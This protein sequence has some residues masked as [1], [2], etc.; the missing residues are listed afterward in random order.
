[1]GQ[2]GWLIAVLLAGACAPRAPARTIRFESTVHSAR[3]PNGMRVL[4]L[5]DHDTNLVEVAIRLDVGS[6]DDPQGKGGLAHLVE[7]LMF[8]IESP[9]DR[10]PVRAHLSAVALGFNAH[11]SWEATTYRAVARA[12]Q[13]AALLDVEASRFSAACPSV[14]QES[15]E[16]EREVVRNEL[17]LRRSYLGEDIDLMRQIYPPTHPYARSIG[18]TDAY[19][20][21]LTLDDACRFIAA[22]YQPDRM[23]V[24][25]TGAIDA[26]RAIRGVAGTLG[27]LA[28]RS[29]RRR[30]AVPRALPAM[31]RV[32]GESIAGDRPALLVEWP[33]PPRYAPGYPAASVA[34]AM[35]QA[36]FRQG[37]PIGSVVELGTGRSPLAVAII[38]LP[39]GSPP[40][41]E[42]IRDAL[43]QVDRAVERAGWIQSD[44]AIDR[45]ANRR[46][47]E[48]LSDF[49]QMSSRVERLAEAF[50]LVGVDHIFVRHLVGFDRL[51]QEDVRDAARQMFAGDRRGVVV[52]T[53]GRRARPLGAQPGTPPPSYAG[54]SHEEQ[55]HAPV[56]PAEADR[57]LRVPL[58]RERTGQ[59]ERFRLDNGLTVILRRT[60]AVPLVSARL[61]FAGGSGDDPAGQEGLGY[62]AGHLLWYGRGG[63]VAPTWRPRDALVHFGDDLD[64]E[65]GADHTTFRTDGLSSHLDAV[66][67]GLASLVIDGEYR[68]DALAAWRRYRT[69]GRRESRRSA[70][71]GARGRVCG[72]GRLPGESG[73]GDAARHCH[74]R[75]GKEPRGGRDDLGRARSTAS[76]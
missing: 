23:V 8:Q 73:A 7:H 35:L 67:S 68:G 50:Q 64:V 56:D 65:V 13:L 27:R 30:P 42:S 71:R 32:E 57:P 38:R 41:E 40:T 31:R 47:R 24:V 5:E 1:M 28:G 69:A 18:G 76:W 29:A 60:P 36:A 48:L 2:R 34:L 39:A 74:G 37:K 11:T 70:A 72:R 33:M 55:W 14:S 26:R 3:L 20:A 66:V 51:D 63:R 54:K 53:P 6:I 49:D 22:Q 61:I 46:A 19:V 62:L 59:V 16:R 17:R 58:P 75:C 52:V 25:M 9:L 43:H 4:A 44:A 45:I 10:R 21:G 15:F 12:D